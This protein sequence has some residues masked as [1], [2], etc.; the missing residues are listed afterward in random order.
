[1]LAVKALQEQQARIEQLEKTQAAL[2]DRL[3]K[4]EAK[5]GK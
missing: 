2:L 1:V 4:L 5:V 3:E